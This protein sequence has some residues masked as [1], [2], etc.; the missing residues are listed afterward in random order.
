MIQ[1][2]QQDA[3]IHQLS[4]LTER[5][6]VLLLAPQQDPGYALAVAWS[7][8]ST[9][10]SLFGA[11]RGDASTG[12]V[13]RAAM[14]EFPKDASTVQDLLLSL[15]RRVSQAPLGSVNAGLDD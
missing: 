14:T 6:L 3:A 10:Q 9:V 13:S 5:K 12:P 8:V 11:K 1:L 2:L 15:E 4:W 7:A